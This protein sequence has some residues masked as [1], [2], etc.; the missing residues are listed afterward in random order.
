M[1]NSKMVASSQDAMFD[2]IIPKSDNNLAIM[3]P[4][5]HKRDVLH[6]W[7]EISVYLDRDVRTCHRW[8]DELELPIHRIDENSPR[9]KVFAYKS[10]IDEWLKERGNNHQDKKSSSIWTN[11]RVIVGLAIGSLVLCVVFAWL[12]FSKTP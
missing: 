12:Y 2:K 5:M 11:K 9:S 8:E 7:K 10:E 3:G 4:D 1:A 6:S